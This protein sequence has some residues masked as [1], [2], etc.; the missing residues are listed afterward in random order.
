VH[1]A[2]VQFE[3]LSAFVMHAQ[4]RVVAHAAGTLTHANVSGGVPPSAKMM[5]GG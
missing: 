2:T 1:E 5:P 3:P 4:S